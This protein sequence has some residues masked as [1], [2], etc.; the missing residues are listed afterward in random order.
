MY[1]PLAAVFKITPL[2]LYDRSALFGGG[3]LFLMVALFYQALASRDMAGR[4][5]SC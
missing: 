2:G 4:K 3:L 1:T 5:I